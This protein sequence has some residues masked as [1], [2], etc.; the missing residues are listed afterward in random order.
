MFDPKRSELDRN[1][2]EGSVAQL[3]VA[4]NTLFQPM[5][6]DRL[7]R[8]AAAAAEGEG[9]ECGRAGQYVWSNCFHSSGT[10]LPPNPP[11]CL[12]ARGFVLLLLARRI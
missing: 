4:P 12:M 9:E 1:R 7:R 6:I 11:M 5:C 3:A 2:K 8:A 10:N